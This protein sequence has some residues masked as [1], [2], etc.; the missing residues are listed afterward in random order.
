MPNRAYASVWVRD[1][2]EE[3]MLMHFEHFLATVPLASSPPG[4]TGMTVRAV[5]FAETPLEEYDLR[6]Y[7]TTPEEIANLAKEHHSGDVCYEVAAR[8]Q[9]GG[10]FAFEARI[11]SPLPGDR[12]EGRCCS[13]W[14]GD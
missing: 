11:K 7:I 9:V 12:G 2:N 5:D 4:F 1:F 3:N 10:D 13:G 6:G 8:A 14:D